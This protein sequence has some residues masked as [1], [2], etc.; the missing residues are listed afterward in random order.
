M[1]SHRE[2]QGRAILLVED[3]AFIRLDL[4]DF[5]EDAGFAVFEAEN[6][7]DAIAMMAANPSIGVVLTDVHMP[8]SMDGLRLAHFVRDRHPPTLLIVASGVAKPTTADLPL[9]ALFFSKPFDPSFVLQ[10]INAAA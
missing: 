8:G 9:G 6:A 2:Y 5:F 1:A 10:A 4:V 7:D 3:E